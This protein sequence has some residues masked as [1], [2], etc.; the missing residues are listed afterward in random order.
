[1]AFPAAAPIVIVP[2]HVLLGVVPLQ[3]PTVNV[4]RCATPLS[5][6]TPSA[7]ALPA[8]IAYVPAPIDNTVFAGAFVPES[9]ST[10]NTWDAGAVSCAAQVIVQAEPVPVEALQVAVWP[11]LVAAPSMNSATCFVAAETNAGLRPVLIAVDPGLPTSNVPLT[12]W[13]E[14]PAPAWPET[15]AEPGALAAAGCAELP[16]PPPPP[17]AAKSMVPAR[18]TNVGSFIGPPQS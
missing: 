18:Q 7:F 16:D 5:A 4:A 10:A 3:M 1:M 8:T 2:G 6:S 9:A 11:A 14:T 15:P 17:Q 13:V 12:A